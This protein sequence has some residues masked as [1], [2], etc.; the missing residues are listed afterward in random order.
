M[1]FKN[2]KTYR[3]NIKTY[4]TNH[5]NQLINAIKIATLAH[6][7]QVD[8]VNLPYIIHPLEIASSVTSIEGKIVTILQDVLKY[9][10]LTIDDLKEYGFDKD[11]I[12][13]LSLLINDDT[14]NYLDYILK[15]KKNPIASD[16]KIEY[17]C[18]IMDSNSL[19]HPKETADFSQK[20]ENY[21]QALNILLRD[22]YKKY[23]KNKFKVN[24]YFELIFNVLKLHTVFN[25]FI[26][27]INFY[28]F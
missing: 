5:V 2:Y 26:C 25:Y 11:I 17:M 6:Q 27:F 22:W 3:E 23:I 19:I 24:I 15:V 10:K 16:V 20:K 28:L 4:N 21:Y 13:T 9:S 8:I 7:D 12:D 14:T 18:Y 1:N